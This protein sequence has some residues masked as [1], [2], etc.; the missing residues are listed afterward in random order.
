METKAPGIN[1]KRCN[2]CGIIKPVSE[3][4]KET[5]AKN[6][7]KPRCKDCLNKYYRENYHKYRDNKL[8][9]LKIKYKENPEKFIER[10]KNN[11]QESQQRIKTKQL[12]REKNRT[13]LREAALS[14]YKKNRLNPEYNINRRVRS[15]IY[16]LLTTKKKKT[17]DLLGYSIDDL[18]KTL[19]RYPTPDH[20]IDH[21]I[22][23]SWFASGTP[24]NLI[25]DLRNLHLL[26]SHENVRK[27]N[28]F[29][30]PIS[31][32]YYDDIKDQIKNKYQNLIKIKEQ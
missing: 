22:P 29:A 2:E 28:C 31:S 6:G 1:S 7:Y 11:P 19:G 15:T 8:S 4:G 27:H 3:F 32:D 5:R 14:Y 16:K 12:W 30:H 20:H 25:C 23:I 24:I 17:F 9:K 26:N 18:I 21:K 13:K 10:V